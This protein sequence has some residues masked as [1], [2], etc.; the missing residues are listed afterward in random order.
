MKVMRIKD[1]TMSY[2]IYDY[3]YNFMRIENLTLALS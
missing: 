3:K 1:G 2:W